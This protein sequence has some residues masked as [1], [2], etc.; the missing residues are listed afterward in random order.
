MSESLCFV[1]FIALSTAS[2][3]QLFYKCVLQNCDRRESSCQANAANLRII[4]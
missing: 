4:E 2:V 1:N 3:I